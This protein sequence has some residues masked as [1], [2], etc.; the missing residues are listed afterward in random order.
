MKAGTTSLRAGQER[1]GIEMSDSLA[2]GDDGIT[3]AMIAAGV[4]VIED[5]EDR[6]LFPEALAREVYRAMRSLERARTAS[7]K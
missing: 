5:V 4:S 3:D 6:M 1:R 2:T 7:C